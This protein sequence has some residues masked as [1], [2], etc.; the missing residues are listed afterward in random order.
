MDKLEQTVV[1]SYKGILLCNKKEQATKI[2]NVEES[3]KHYAKWKRLTQVH[4]TWFHAYD[5]LEQDKLINGGQKIRTRV[6]GLT[7]KREQELSG[8]M[9]M[10]Y[11]MMSLHY[12]GVFMYRNPKFSQW[13]A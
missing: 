5:I 13:C 9:L 4:A 8:V 12:A 10:F 6:R 3:Q 11:N 1:Y 2:H 7:E